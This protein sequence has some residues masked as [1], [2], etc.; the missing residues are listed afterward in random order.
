MRMTFLV[1]ITA[2]PIAAADPAIYWHADYAAGRTQ[3][4]DANK[5]VCL[6]IG[7][8]HCLYCRKLEAITLAEA[9]IQNM[10][11]KQYVAIK[12]DGH[13]EAEL[14]RALKISLYPTTVLAGPDGTIHAIINGYVSAAEMKMHM[15]K[16]LVAIADMAKK[17]G[18]RV[19]KTSD[20]PAA[21]S[22]ISAIE[23]DALARSARDAEAKA[24]QLQ[25]QLAEALY[26]HGDVGG[27]AKCWEKVLAMSPSSPQAEA[28]RGLLVSLKSGGPLVATPASL[29][30]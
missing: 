2:L 5:P 22:G 7:S 19:A 16:T 15:D 12:L 21:T 26:Q 6:V 23:L 29:K 20:V 30:K 18:D 10:I 17:S 1:L 13:R 25:M 14:A 24:V 9:S 11:S 3:A 4:A 27:A 8:E 28:A